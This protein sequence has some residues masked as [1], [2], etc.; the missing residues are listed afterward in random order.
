MSAP[1]RAD[2]DGEDAFVE[3]DHVGA[4]VKDSSGDET[5]RVCVA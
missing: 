4:G 1:E 2:R 3:D 5:S